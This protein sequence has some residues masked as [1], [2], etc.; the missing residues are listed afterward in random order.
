M[1][2]GALF[3]LIWLSAFICTAQKLTQDHFFLK[4]GLFDAQAG[5][6]L[7]VGDFA[8]S[9]FTLPAGYAETGYHVKISLNYDVTSYLG[10]VL[11]YQYTE[12]P[13][14][15]DKFLSDLK[16]AHPDDQFISYK[17]D[18]WKLQG[19]L[20]GLYYPFKTAKTTI[21]VRLLGGLLSGVLPEDELN[22]T[23]PYLNNRNYNYQRSEVS[24]SNLGFQAGIKGRH[25]LYKQLILTASIDYLQTKINFENI[26]VI[27]TNIGV[28]YKD[29]DYTQKF[30]LF[31]FSL[32]LGI[33]F[34]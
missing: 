32:G 30:Q 27:D 4:K 14:N 21:D 1:K 24:A 25:Q 9:D 3:C 18:P 34:D 28:G 13:F 7:P 29:E 12:N 31:N 6:S 22:V 8:L 5:I 19:M 2:H 26:R 17:S 16:G 23:R 33:Q 20:L 11:Q 10:F 15:S